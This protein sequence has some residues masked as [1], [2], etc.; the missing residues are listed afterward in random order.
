[1]WQYDTPGYR[2]EPSLSILDTLMWNSAD[3]VREMLN[4]R[5]TGSP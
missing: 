3:A 5:L 4:M 2:F 1:M